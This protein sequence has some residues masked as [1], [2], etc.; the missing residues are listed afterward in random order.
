MSISHCYVADDQISG[1]CCAARQ[2]CYCQLACGQSI[3]I[4]RWVGLYIPAHSFLSLRL[5]RVPFDVYCWK[6]ATCYLSGRLTGVFHIPLITLWT[7][8]LAE[9]ERVLYPKNPT[10]EAS[11]LVPSWWEWWINRCG[12]LGLFVDHFLLL[13]LY[14]CC[15]GSTLWKWG[16]YDQMHPLKLGLNTR[17][18]ITFRY[19]WVTLPNFE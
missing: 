7:S 5:C 16:M 19:F 10:S 11:Y 13:L 17:N 3:G 1:R 6:I 14:A 8:L 18:P 12:P 4:T 15:L 2:R 9:V